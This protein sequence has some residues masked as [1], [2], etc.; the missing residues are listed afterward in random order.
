MQHSILLTEEEQVQ[1]RTK[2]S[3]RL[4]KK[5]F[6]YPRWINENTLLSLSIISFCTLLVLLGS[7]LWIAV[8]AA[9]ILLGIQFWIYLNSEPKFYIDL[10]NEEIQTAITRDLYT[11]E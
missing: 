4:G 11:K 3:K 1:I 8:P 5:V 7:P 9:F 2:T 6:A 10:D